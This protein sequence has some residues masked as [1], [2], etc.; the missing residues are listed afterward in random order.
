MSKCKQPAVAAFEGRCPTCARPRFSPDTR[1]LP[2]GLLQEPSRGPRRPI[3]TNPRSILCQQ[4]SQVNSGRDRPWLRA[5]SRSTRLP[6]TTSNWPP[7]KWPTWKVSASSDL[8]PPK[9]SENW[10]P[11]AKPPCAPAPDCEYT[12]SLTSPTIDSP[13]DCQHRCPYITAADP[14]QPLICMFKV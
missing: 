13:I 7:A 2:A 4:F 8:I 5:F 12:V 11:N 3:S 10:I 14:D 9:L 1:L 6:S